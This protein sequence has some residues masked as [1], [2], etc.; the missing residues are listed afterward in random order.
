MPLMALAGPAFVT[1]R[2]AWL[3]TCVLVVEEL[4]PVFG[5]VVALEIVAVLNTVV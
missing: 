4:L 2:S 3:K 1:E 5:S